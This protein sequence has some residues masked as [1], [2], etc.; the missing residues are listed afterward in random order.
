M[1]RP[2][3]RLA[4]I[5]VEIIHFEPLAVIFRN[6]VFDEEIKILKQLSMP[7][8]SRALVHSAVTGEAI[9]AKFR[10]SKKF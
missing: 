8:L 2:F 1:D 4:P 10:I 7:K 5:K 6:V 9:P 3:L